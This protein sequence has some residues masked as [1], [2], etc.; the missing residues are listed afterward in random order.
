[1]NFN[2][3]EI[4]KGE[5]E[6]NDIILVDTKWNSGLFDFNKTTKKLSKVMKIYGKN[7][8]ITFARY[9]YAYDEDGYKKAEYE[10]ILKYKN[11]YFDDNG[12][13]VLK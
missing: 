11:D 7:D 6:K 12:K 13:L 3:A 5:R 10:D 9:P 8:I 2:S 4:K 1:M